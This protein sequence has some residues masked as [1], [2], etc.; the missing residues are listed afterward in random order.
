MAT[1]ITLDTLRAALT[2][3]PFAGIDAL[4]RS[5]LA[6]GRT[7]ADV[8][9]ELFPLVRSARRTPGLTEDA[10]EALL[11]ALDALNGNCHPDCRYSDRA[12]PP[13][14]ANGHTASVAAPA[15]TDAR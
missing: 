4:I 8:H 7:T 3:D 10:S 15:P 11:G 5:E 6:A 9:A 12:V 2:A 13:A 14:S 1:M